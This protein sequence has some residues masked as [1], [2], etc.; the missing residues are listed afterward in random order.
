[1]QLDVQRNAVKRVQLLSKEN[2]GKRE[3]LLLRVEESLLF[4]VFFLIGYQF[5]TCV[6]PI[7]F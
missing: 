5:K 6:E 2:S 3:S 4:S 7:L 1:M